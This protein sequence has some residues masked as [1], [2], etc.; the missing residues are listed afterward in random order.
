MKPELLAT[1]KTLVEQ[2]M[3]T[4]WEAMQAAQV[5]ANEESK[6]SAGDK[7]E[8]ARAMGQLDREMHG[9]Q[10]D[11]AHQERLLLEKISKNEVFTKIAFGALA[12]T[13]AGWFF[14]AVSAGVL[15]HDGQKVMVVSPQSPIGQALM[16]R[17]AGESFTF[18]GKEDRI[19]SV[20]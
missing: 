14:V 6:S 17:K 16:G 1:I 18:R 19:L 20:E 7:Y 10:Y 3:Q 13:T 11:Q 5:S 9:R 4:A 2:R 12:Q 15:T 8:T